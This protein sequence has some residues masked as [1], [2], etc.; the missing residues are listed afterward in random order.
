MASIHRIEPFTKQCNFVIWLKKFELILKIGKVEES[1]KID[2]T[3]YTL[4][5]T[6]KSGYTNF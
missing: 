3:S 1:Q 5:Y 6:Y 2:Y 4:V